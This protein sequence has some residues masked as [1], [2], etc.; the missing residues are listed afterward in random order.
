VSRRLIEAGAPAESCWLPVLGFA[1]VHSRGTVLVD[2]GLSRRWLKP[3]GRWPVRLL[4]R[5][6]GVSLGVAM[7]CRSRLLQCGLR[8]DAVEHGLL[9][10]LHVD[11]ADGVADLPRTRFRVSRREHQAA[12]AHRGLGALR[13]GYSP[14]R[15][16]DLDNI[17]TFEWDLA[18]DLKPFD[19]AF[20]LFGDGTIRA[21]PSPGHTAGHCCVLVRVDDGSEVL[22]TGDAAF[23]TQQLEAGVGLG[24]FPRRVAA[25]LHEAE[26]TLHKLRALV[27]R[28]QPLAVL[29]SHDP[30]LGDDVAAGPQLIYGQT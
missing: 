10:H 24:L 2:A 27:A 6:P 22:L 14:G 11:H 15:L 19:V 25:D 28:R 12:R 9:T 13:R 8:P 7:D 29:P 1:L 26:R 18:T 5:L 21:F 3:P 16:A 17:E 20:D 4:G 23:T 30:E